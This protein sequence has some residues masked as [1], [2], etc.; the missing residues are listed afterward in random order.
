MKFTID[1][2]MFSS[3]ILNIAIRYGGDCMKSNKYIE[4]PLA[5]DA[6]T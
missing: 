6:K 5:V 4:I 2:S 3:A 1:K